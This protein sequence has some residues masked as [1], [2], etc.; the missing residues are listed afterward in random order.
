MVACSKS[1]ERSAGRIAD[2]EPLPPPLPVA[3]H[4]GLEGAAAVVRLG[5]LDVV[6]CAPGIGMDVG[7]GL[8]RNPRC[9]A[10]GVEGQAATGGGGLSDWQAERRLRRRGASGAEPD[11]SGN[12]VE[13]AGVNNIFREK[14]PMQSYV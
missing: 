6:A 10:S 12:P 14:C 13:L 9:A 3:K 2:R 4:R 11:R 8:P 7:S 1:R 5:A